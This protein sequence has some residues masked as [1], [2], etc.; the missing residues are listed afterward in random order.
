[1]VESIL[2]VRVAL[3]QVEMATGGRIARAAAKGFAETR[4]LMA[5][6]MRELDYIEWARKRFLVG[7]ELDIL[8]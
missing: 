5:R 6:A 4:A 3:L 8:A 2:P 1:M 7:S